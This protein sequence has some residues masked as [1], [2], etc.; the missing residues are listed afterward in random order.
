[1]GT[2]TLKWALAIGIV[3]GLLC[4]RPAFSCGPFLE[5]AIFTYTLHPDL[6]L[7]SY[8]Q[9]QLGILQ[10]TYAQSYLYVAYRYLIGMGFNHEEQEALLAL[11]DERLNPQAD[12]LNP[13]ANAAIKAWSEA[14]AR[15]ADGGPPPQVNVFKTLEARNGLFYSH[16]YVNCPADAF[17]TAARTLTERIGQFG[18][19]SDAVRQWVRAQDQVFG[20]CSGARVIPAPAVPQSPEILH[21]DRA[22][23]IA[24]AHFY[25]GEL[26]VAER[27]FRDIADD[28]A[29][30]WRPLAPYLVARALLRQGSLIP[31]YHEVDKAKLTEAKQ[32]LHAILGDKNLQVIHPATNR[33]LAVVRFRLEP[34]ER[35]HELAQSLLTPNIGPMLKQHLWDYTLLLDGV[36]DARNGPDT[37][38]ARR[39]EVT[40]WILTF[41]DTS[42]NAL[43]HALGRWT[44]TSALPW[45]VASLSKVGGEHP[46]VPE[47]L[48]AAEKVPQE[49]PA[50][51]SVTSHRLR[52]LAGSGKPDVS[53]QQLDG[54]LSQAGPLFPPSA[55][56]LLLALRLQ[57]ARTLHEFLLYAPR[58]PVAIT[59]NIDGREL[60]ED[61]ET[62][63]RLKLIARDRPLFDADAARVLNRRLPLN[64]LRELVHRSILPTHLRRELA[65]AVL[66]RS[67][68]L[69]EEDTTR[70]LVPVVKTLIPELG[71]SLDEYRATIS[72]EARAF[73]GLFM[74]LRFPGL[75]PYV[76]DNVGRL[77][78]LDQIDNYRGNWWCAVDAAA[79]GTARETDRLSA[80]LEILYHTGQDPALEFLSAGQ[81]SA[82]QHELQRLASS[83]P[84]PNYL[85]QQV[86]AWGQKT[87]GDPRVPEAL[88]LAVKATRFGCA[89]AD[90]GRF[91]KAAFDLLHERYPKSPWAQ[92]TKYWYK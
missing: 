18:A 81:V 28:P 44:T 52:L 27:L 58:A 40:D 1:M 77:T 17:L 8:A 32:I 16:A 48:A 53:R 89:D 34:D 41:Q 11:W 49:A 60:P 55:R 54:L 57:L 73:T 9:G 39:D 80:P 2:L 90:T 56:N 74:I 35:L 14:R 76:Q 88:H 50:F 51:A 43:E 33:L 26:A 85:S 20:N 4:S 71:P 23:Q 65:M 47:L 21:K 37:R 86:T 79:P 10:P 25:A 87:P 15:I 31:R 67:L 68:L 91:S 13:N 38:T 12:L 92:K 82:A 24:A 84:A 83:G 61:L 19:D 62:N 36:A 69:R 75:K 63:E 22:Y 59:Y 29:S 42:P 45:L 64:T 7:T 78:P 70:D 66:T 46:R 72:R 5:Q 3:V 30:P 6:P